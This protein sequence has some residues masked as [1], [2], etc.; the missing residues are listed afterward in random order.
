MI[1][2]P[3]DNVS[4]GTDR[5]RRNLLHHGLG[6]LV[7]A[8]ITR[9]MQLLSVAGTN[10][11]APPQFDCGLQLKQIERHS[12]ILHITL[13]SRLTSNDIIKETGAHMGQA[14]QKPGIQSN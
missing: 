14:Q 7:F 4:F 5:A 13:V 12:L 2:P 11:S 9:S 10:R 8:V 1:D 6:S 3:F